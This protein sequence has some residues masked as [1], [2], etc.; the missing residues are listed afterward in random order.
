MNSGRSRIDEITH[1]RE[2]E[3][4]RRESLLERDVNQLEQSLKISE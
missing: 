3:L 1:E 4:Q 2:L